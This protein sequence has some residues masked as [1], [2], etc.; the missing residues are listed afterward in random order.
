MSRRRTSAAAA[1]GAGVVVAIQ[2]RINGALGHALDDGVLAA[3]VNFS[4][5]L[6]VLVVLVAARP[7]ARDALR[8]LRGQLRSREIPW[9]AL[10][11]GLGGAMYVAGQ[12]VTIAALG[13]ALFTVATVAGQTGMGLVVDRFGLGPT[14]Q[15]PVTVLR[16]AAAVL[17]TVAVGLA[18]SG[19][20]S[21]GGQGAWL[22]LVLAFSA[23]AAVAFQAAFNGR[24]SVAT[25][26]PTVAALVNFVVGLVAL[27][28]IVAAAH[29]IGAQPMPVW[30]T[31]SGDLWLYSGGL[32]GVVFVVTAAWTVRALGVLLF[33][34]VVLS[35]T[36]LGAVLVDAVAPTPGAQLTVNLALGIA[37]TLVAVA[38]AVVRPRRRVRS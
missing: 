31:A 7:S 27:L 28:L 19:R 24:V 1:F 22:F 26:Q 2:G 12:G 8:G 21:S 3:V 29:G 23:G 18:A 30:P 34:L 36:L 20:D 6:T 5:G 15:V 14:G 9:W 38:L 4:V 10:L 37:L 35:G 16:V 11:A 25:G 13:V 17:A 32:L 33:S